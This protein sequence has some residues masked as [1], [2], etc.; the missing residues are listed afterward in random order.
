MDRSLSELFR[1]DPLTGC[2]NYLGFLEALA[3]HAIT[4]PPAKGIDKPPLSRY[5]INSSQFS[6]LL[7]V[8]MNAL[9]F[10]NETKGR[11]YGDSVLRWLS[12][13]LQEESNG[14]VFRICG[15]EFAVLLKLES[16]QGHHELIERI[17]RRMEREARQLG[18]PGTAANMALV[19]FNPTPI[20]LETILVKGDEAVTSVKNDQN[21]DF[22]IINAIDSQFSPEAQATSKSNGSSDFPLALSWLSF[23]IHHVLQM[24]RILNDIQHE[25]YTDSISGLP[26]LN[27]AMLNLE[28][29]LQ[30]SIT[31]H[32]SFSM[33]MIDGDNLRMCNNNFSYAVGDEII[34]KMSAVFKD[35]LRPNDFVARWRTGDEFIV[36][37]P[38]TPIEGAKI[39]A[40]HFRLAI[41]QASKSWLFPTTISIGV[42][43]YPIHG[44]HVNSLIDKVEAA[45][46]QAKKLGKDQVVLAD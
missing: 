25:A 19:A 29:T 27:A 34:R 43:S 2:K 26:N 35:N 17:L 42:A 28:Q 40:E 13:V 1:V 22:M 24:G 23:N 5:W 31:D 33:L 20:D 18:F 10:F 21:C 11:P 37:L 6:A 46:K 16:G 9:Q 39:I 44:D 45:N 3:E 4:E 36:I 38:D 15:H 12:L 14:D 8:E 30:S 41:K 32:K 7:L